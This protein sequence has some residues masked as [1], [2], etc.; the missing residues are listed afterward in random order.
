MNEIIIIGGSNYNE[1]GLVRSFGENGIKPCGIIIGNRRDIKRASVYYSKYWKRIDIVS[2]EDDALVVLRSHYSGICEKPIIITTND[3]IM[4]V[5]D[6]F[7]EILKNDFILSSFNQISNGIN[8]YADKEKQA[9]F[10]KEIGF[11]ML[12][13]QVLDLQIDSKVESPFVFPVFLKP[14]KGGEG[15][16]YD[17]SVAFCNSDFIH[18]VEKLRLK[19]YRRILVQPYLK[20]RKEYLITGAVSPRNSLVSFSVLQG[21][22][23]WPTTYGIS[24]FSRLVTEKRIVEYASGLLKAVCFAGYDGPIDVEL[25]ETDDGKIYVNEFNWRSS[26]RN[27]VALYNGVYSTVWWA[28]NHAGIDVSSKKLINDINGYAMYEFDDIRHCFHHNIQVKDWLVDY[29]HTG[30][31]SAR[32]FRDPVPVLIETLSFIKRV[33]K[34]KV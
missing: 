25:F 3:H 12:E 4:Q 29:M 16:K 13:T 20:N 14:V 31:F 30:A 18:I 2:N 24:S 8:Q 23:Q 34:K 27:W 19:N 6:S 9:T 33:I 28:I 21:I 15:S 7:Y 17:I 22:R 32:F 10:A 5:F 11:H 26:G 1:L